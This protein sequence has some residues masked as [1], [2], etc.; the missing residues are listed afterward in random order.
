MILKFVKRGAA[1]ARTAA[2]IGAGLITGPGGVGYGVSEYEDFQ[3]IRQE[4][5]AQD[6]AEGVATEG[7]EMDAIAEGTVE[8]SAEDLRV[9]M[10]IEEGDDLPLLVDVRQDHEWSTGHIPGAV[11]IPLSELEQR[12]DEVGKDR[13]VVV[14]C[15]SGMRSIDGSYVL[16][17]HDYPQVRSL[18]GGIVGWQEGGNST[19]VP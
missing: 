9:M 5:A 10:E 4:A 17:R 16:K 19:E 11:H 3:R 8:M 6:R 15:H 1:A 13:L 7:S 2:K 12:L 18:A 14:Y